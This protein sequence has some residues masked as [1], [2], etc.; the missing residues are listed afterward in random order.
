MR[1][2][3]IGGAPIRD[4]ENQA[5]GGV[6]M[7]VATPGR[8]GHMLNNKIFSLNF[9]KYFVLDEA[10]INFFNLNLYFQLEFF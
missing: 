6:H 10:G 1:Y 5:K 7:V 3:Y 4:Q 8:L 2:H 9:C